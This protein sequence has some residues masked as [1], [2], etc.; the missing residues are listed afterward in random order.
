M[1]A[2]IAARRFGLGFADALTAANHISSAVAATQ[3]GLLDTEAFRRAVA[4]MPE[5]IQAQFE[6]T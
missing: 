3:G 4:I 1:G 5:K 2:V 6:K